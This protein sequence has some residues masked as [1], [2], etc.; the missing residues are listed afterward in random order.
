MLS[1]LRRVRPAGQRKSPDSI[2]AR[3][4]R[5]LRLEAL[6]D[7]LTPAV[8][9]WTGLGDGSGDV[10]LVFHTN[11][12]NTA[13]LVTQNDLVGLIVDSI[14]FDANAG[15]VGP[16]TFANGGLSSA[17]YTINGNVVTIDTA[18]TGQNPFGIDIANGVT[19]GTGI[20]ETFNA[21]ITLLNTN[22]TFRSQQNDAR[23]TFTGVIDLGTR[24]LTID[25]AG[26]KRPDPASASSNSNGSCW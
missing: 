10:D 24:T 22:A 20:T 11:L 13:N 18:G 12:V 14:T 17:G 6:E 7:R 15:T 25:N 23:M 4:S 21:G 2:P 9:E 1:W 8:H 16:T 5:H 26:V 3:R 19:T